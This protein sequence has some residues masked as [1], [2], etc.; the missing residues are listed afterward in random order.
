MARVKSRVRR[1][2]APGR[3]R[4]IAGRL[5]GSV[6]EVPDRPGLRP[7]PNRLR[8]TLFNWLQPA[9]PGA[10]CLDLFAGSGALGIEALSRGAG[11]VQLVERDAGLAEALRV[12]LQRL[13]PG[14]DACVHGGD[15]TGFLDAADAAP[16]DIVFV[17]PPFAAEL[18]EPV[19]AR[20]EAGGW[21]APQALIYLEMPAT[22]HV[23]VPSAWNIER[24]K[25]VGDVRALLY[26]RRP[27]PLS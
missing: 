22:M 17:D 2:A 10:R 13:G 14:L 3:V 1:G 16:F 12:N 25:C 18:W 9:L 5:R 21:L 23:T 19:S 15:A 6:L 20:L 24:D 4:I 26:R 27:D 11:A 8:E 7:T